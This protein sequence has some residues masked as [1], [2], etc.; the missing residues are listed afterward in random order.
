MQRKEIILCPKYIYASSSRHQSILKSPVG[1][2]GIA[3]VVLV[4]ICK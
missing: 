1:Q 3:A 4:S 2:F